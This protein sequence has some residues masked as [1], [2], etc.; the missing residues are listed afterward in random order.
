MFKTN[1]TACLPTQHPNISYKSN[2]SINETCYCTLRRYSFPIPN[3][4]IKGTALRFSQ[5][6]NNPIPPCDRIATTMADAIIT[7]SHHM[8][9][10]LWH[11]PML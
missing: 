1:C 6:A 7:W 10:A 8:R 4:G 9:T 5:R 3:I 2:V 11:A